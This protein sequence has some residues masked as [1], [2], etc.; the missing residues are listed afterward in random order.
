MIVTTFA[1]YAHRADGITS[2]GCE[3]MVGQGARQESQGN[4]K[5]VSKGEPCVSSRTSLVRHPG[6]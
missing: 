3:P 4:G 6:R 5:D 2:R 1:S